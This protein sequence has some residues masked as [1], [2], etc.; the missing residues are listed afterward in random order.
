MKN[1]YLGVE[2]LG[3]RGASGEVGGNSGKSREFPEASGKS[4]TLHLEIVT[5]LNKKSRLFNLHFF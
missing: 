5:S 4:D 1:G 2:N 3:R